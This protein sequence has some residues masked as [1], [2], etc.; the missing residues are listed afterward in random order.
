LR[1]IKFWMFAVIL[2]CISF[3]E[4]YAGMGLATKFVDVILENLQPGESYN[5]RQLKNVPYIVINKGTEPIGIVVEVEKPQKCKPGYEPIP[6]PG[7]VQLIPD[8]FFLQPGENSASDI[9]ISV[10]RDKGLIGKNFQV[11][12]WA[13]TLQKGNIGVGV[14]S[15][16]RFSIGTKAPETINKERKKMVS[17]MG[18]DYELSPRNIYLMDVPAG[19][20]YDVKKETGK[21]IKVINKG[22]EKLYLKFE[23]IEGSKNIVLPAGYKKVLKPEFISFSPEKM[24]IGPMKIKEVKLKIKIPDEEEYSVENLAFII[25]ALVYN[26]NFPIETY[27][28]VLITPREKMKEGNGK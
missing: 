7:W 23:A 24:K 18:M 2:S 26:I 19:V 15:R 21:T 1:I 20:K 11:G 14:N 16:I 9:I 4:T 22:T 10:P 13:H 27:C 5:F 8:K 3:V 6:D 12:L 28:N 25:K 17:L